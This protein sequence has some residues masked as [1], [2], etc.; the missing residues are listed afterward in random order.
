MECFSSTVIYF[1][2]SR[3]SLTSPHPHKD[4]EDAGAFS[5][6]LRSLSLKRP[7]NYECFFSLSGR[8]SAANEHL[9]CTSRQPTVGEALL[10]LLTS[11]HKLFSV[12]KTVEFRA[13]VGTLGL[14]LCVCVC[15]LGR[16]IMS[17]SYREYEWHTLSPR[18][19]CS[20][21]GSAIVRAFRAGLKCISQKG[22]RFVLMHTYTHCLSRSC[23]I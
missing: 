3:L 16:L 19:L 15:V 5:D 13:D 11:A 6:C 17:S 20:A 7:F 10:F 22:Y 21:P 8:A 1:F 4:S 23:I 12:W 2:L 18:M 9:L 14:I